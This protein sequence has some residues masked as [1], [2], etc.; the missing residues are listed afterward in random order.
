MSDPKWLAQA[1][2]LAGGHYHCEDS[3]YCCS[4]CT[5]DRDPGEFCGADDSRRGKPC[6][7]GREGKVQAVALALEEAHAEGL[8]SCL[9]HRCREHYTVPQLNESEHQG[10]ECG[11]CAHAAGKAEGREEERARFVAAH[12]SAAES[13]LECPA[14]VIDGWLAREL[15]DYKMVID[16]CTAV[17]CHV[18]RGRV[19]KPQTLPGEVIAIADDFATE[20]CA[21][22]YAEGK[23]EGRREGDKFVRLHELK[24]GWDSYGAPAIAPEAVAAAQGFDVVPTSAGG[25]QLE[26][27]RHG[28]DLEIEWGPDGTV[29]SVSFER[30]A[31]LPK[32]PE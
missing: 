6:D 31:L 11:A 14:E 19:S 25:V 17:Y 29:V 32:A 22:A 28:C 15:S 23:A 7:C 21:E 12:E 13:I 10:S 2:E 5:V 26:W 16:H 20:D 18:T 27:H 30:R 8:T 24:A 4:Q 1:E 9:M 3:W